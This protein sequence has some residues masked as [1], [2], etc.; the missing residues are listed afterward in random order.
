MARR[1]RKSVTGKCNKKN[2]INEIH[3]EKR[4]A[5]VNV[6]KE[7]NKQIS[8]ECNKKKDYGTSLMN[9]SLT[10]GPEPSDQSFDFYFYKDGSMIK[11][12][13]TEF[14]LGTKTG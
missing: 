14:S 13:K 1:H 10:F 5:Q 6:G 4:K 11:S 2:H 7:K 9:Q 3:G 12:E 8:Q